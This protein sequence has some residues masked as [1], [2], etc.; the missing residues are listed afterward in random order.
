MY[1]KKIGACVILLTYSLTLLAISSQ[2]SINVYGK[3]IC[4]GK[5]VSFVSVTDGFSV[6]KTDKNGRYKLKT[7]SDSKFVYYTLP[8]GYESPVNEGIPVF[9][10][11]ID[12]LK[13]YQK[14]DFR[15]SKC[16]QS[17]K[18]YSFIVWADPQVIEPKEFDYLKE[19]VSDLN[20]TVAGMPDKSLV[21]GISCGDM[22][23]DRLNLLD[24]YK[25]VTAQTGIPFYQSI[26]NHDMDY[27]NRSDE[28]SSNTYMSKFG[29]AYYSFE[30][31]KV[32]YIVLK[33]VFY[34]GYTYH[35]LGYINEAQLSWLEKDLA[36]V[37]PG[38][39][40]VLIMHIPTCYGDA[41]QA[42]SYSTLLSNSVMNKSELYRIL[43]P[44]KAHI[45]AG[46]SHIQWNTVVS[47]TIFEHVHAAASGAWWQGKVCLDGSPLGYTV[48]NVIGDSLTWYFKGLNLDK[49]DQFKL[50][51]T[52]SD[53]SNVGYFIANVYNYDPAWKVFWYEN[54]VYQGEMER[55]WGKD[56]LASQLYQ[57]GKNKKYDWLSVGDTHH[58]FRA[59]IKIPGDKVTV[60]VTDRFG[61]SYQ[62]SL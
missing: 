40:V 7:T 62:K 24:S 49:T 39:T 33:D 6:V 36:D 23:F 25:Q 2:R 42:D 16:E 32:H 29:P 43:S 15:L 55:Y 59:K 1:L 58:L 31:G 10:A 35:Y 27:N 50:Y 8:S 28:L 18:N 14:I 47:N 56:P 54:D 4:S 3:I 5:A 60:K 21:F 30:K 61:N 48:Y 38:S 53:T 17:Q 52:S 51:A 26:G 41:E 11:S 19:V 45:L 44:Y 34:Y 9:Y 46:H 37:K 20:N 57:P 12:S 22:V 13:E